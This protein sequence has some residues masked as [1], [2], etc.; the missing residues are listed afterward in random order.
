MYTTQRIVNFPRIP[1]ALELIQS[2]VQDLSEFI[3]VE[4]AL[5][6]ALQT[7]SVKSG[8]LSGSGASA[9]KNL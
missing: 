6:T 4:T 2:L 5:N 9:V 1:Q 3:A 7:L 8:R